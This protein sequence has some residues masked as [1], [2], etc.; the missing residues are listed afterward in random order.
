MLCLQ[1][2]MFP[3]RLQLALP[4]SPV[5][6]MLLQIGP[7]F[8][9]TKTKPCA[10]SSYWAR[11]SN[12]FETLINNKQIR[13]IILNRYVALFY[14]DFYSVYI[15][16]N[17]IMLSYWPITLYSCVLAQKG[18]CNTWLPDFLKIRL[19]SLTLCSWP[20][21]S[22][23]LSASCSDLV[24]LFIYPLQL[25]SNNFELLLTEE[26]FHH[27]LRCDCTICFARQRIGILTEKLPPTPT[28]L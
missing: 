1:T 26:G 3:C 5:V 18:Y 7:T 6:L 19:N 10:P 11:N 14:W 12:F 24:I 25:L 22:K 15:A 27:H 2:N 13:I 17:Y 9:Y 21:L 16:A 28:L 4:T 23:T 8:K 20:D